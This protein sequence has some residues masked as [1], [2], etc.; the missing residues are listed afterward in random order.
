MSKN[1]GCLSDFA[2]DRLRTGELNGSADAVP[3]GAHLRGC[4]RCQGRLRE[5]D[6]VVPPRFDFSDVAVHVPARA[7][8]R[9]WRGW[10]RGLW[11]LPIAAT[12][13]VAALVPRRPPDARSKGGAWQLGVFA[14]YPSGRVE[15]I[16]P[17]AAL[18]PGDRLRFQ[19]SAPEDGFVSVISL[20]ARR[21]VTPFAPAAGEMT[22][23][24][25]GRQ[26]LEAAVRLD[27]ALGPER[28]LLV[29][30]SRP[31]PLN[32]VISAG[33]AALDAAGGSAAQVAGLDLPCAQ[34]TFWIRK[35]ARP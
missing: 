20:D 18:A 4:D 27:D 11:L 26:L 19:V 10:L 32:Q 2:L 25:P 13:V 35:E 33:R 29:A 9:T 28:L 34:S 22:A 3:A 7:P 23:V 21:A 6:A 15:A 1:E 14:Q 5:M 12:V 24:H 16:S 17:G 8:R 31:L 30:C